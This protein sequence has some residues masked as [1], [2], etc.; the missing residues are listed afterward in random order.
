[1][2]ACTSIAALL[3][4]M[5]HYDKDE[6][7]MATSDLCEVLKRNAPVA[8]D[9]SSHQQTANPSGYQPNDQIQTSQV[10]DSRT[11]NNI[12]DAVLKLLGDPS[13][14]VQTVAVKTLVVLFTSVHEEQ[15]LKITST[16]GALILDDTKQD[17]R[18]VYS[19]GLRKLCKTVPLTMGDNVAIHLASGLIDGI[20]K[21]STLVGIPSPMESKDQAKTAEDITVS[22]LEVMTDMLARFG[23]LPKIT[24][25]HEKLVQMVLTQ[26]SSES[27]LV[28]KRACNV[29]GCLSTVISDQLLY[30]LVES[31]LYRIDSA[32]GVGRRSKRRK[33]RSSVSPNPLIWIS[34]KIAKLLIPE[35]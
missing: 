4:K 1:M 13:N 6:R 12:C 27:H 26:L 15:I 3:S 22:C 30:K 35:L 17:L 7:Y 5:Q 31:L 33:T 2:S 29:I 16:L 11:E 19:D 10:I 21:N 18:D 23:G 9:I 20:R 32:E 8:L 28:R 25:Q 14:D 24:Q 34:L